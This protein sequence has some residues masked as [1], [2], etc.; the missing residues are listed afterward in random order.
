[1]NYINDKLYNL[2]LMM[3]TDEPYTASQIVQH[4]STKAN[5]YIATFRTTL[6]ELANM[7][8]TEGIKD[9]VYGHEA[10]CDSHATCNSTLRLNVSKQSAC[11]HV[12]QTCARQSVHTCV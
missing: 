8:E 6:L 5:D 12:I 11:S 9:L 3:V 7:P 2:S 1:M 10:G 4:L